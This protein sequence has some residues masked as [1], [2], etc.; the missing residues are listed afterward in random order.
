MPFSTDIYE[1]WREKQ[2][3]KYEDL[4][5]KLKKHLKRGYSVLDI[6]IGKAWLEEF[7]ENHGIRFKEV[8]GID[9]DERMTLPQRKGITYFITDEFLTSKKFDLVICFDTLHLLKEPHNLLGYSKNLVLVS[10]PMAFK[11][12]LEI[13]KSQRIMEEGEIGK[14]EK[15]YFILIKV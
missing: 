13:F 1:S 14:Q 3:E 7:L 6:G 4:L 15:D 8:V 10:L 5:P 12:K 2:F 11:N 9:N